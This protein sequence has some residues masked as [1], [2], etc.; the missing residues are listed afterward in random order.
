MVP[1]AFRLPVGWSAQE[2][3]S[4][5]FPAVPGIPDQLSRRTWPFLALI[6][7]QPDG[8]F[9]CGLLYD[10]YHVSGRTGLSASVILCNFFLL[11]ATEDEL[12][13]L[14]RETFDTPEEIVTAGWRVD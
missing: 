1:S 6:R 2:R 5:F 9:D 4:K 3:P 8:D 10:A 7:H 14:P 13:A 12:L 11:P